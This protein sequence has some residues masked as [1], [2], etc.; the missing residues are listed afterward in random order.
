M[1]VPFIP[2]ELFL[3]IAEQIPELSTLLSLLLS[4]RRLSLLV[5]PVLLRKAA[6]SSTRFRGK[7]ALEHAV[8][9]GD[10]GQVHSMLSAS[11]L[12]INARNV[13]SW[14][15]LDTAIR[16]RHPD[17]V[18]LLLTHGADV[19]AHGRRYGTTPLALAVLTAQH[20]VIRMLLAKGADVLALHKIKGTTIG[21]FREYEFTVL[22][23]AICK[24]D[25]PTVR[26][27]L[28]GADC[29]RKGQA[30]IE[31]LVQAWGCEDG[32]RPWD[33]AAKALRSLITPGAHPL[34]HDYPSKCMNLYFDRVENDFFSIKGWA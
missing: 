8:S 11:T 31:A 18:Q 13:N 25:L 26:L 27:L 6:E 16:S 5:T 30:L 4:N 10:L 14:T 24:K 19:A 22:H 28:E 7:T 3:E 33:E 34:Q 21:L 2:N 32:E 12:R 1:P 17:M 15:L 23:Y 29:G 20:D 9:C